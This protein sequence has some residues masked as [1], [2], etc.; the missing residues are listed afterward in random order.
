MADY[1]LHVYTLQARAAVRGSVRH[2][3]CSLPWPLERER[4]LYVVPQ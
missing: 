3:G 1:T 2:G 4:P